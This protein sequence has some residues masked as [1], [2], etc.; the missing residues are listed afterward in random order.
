MRHIDRS[1]RDLHA[2]VGFQGI[3]GAGDIPDAAG[4]LQVVLGYGPVVGGRDIQN[5]QTVQDQVLF[6]EDDPVRL[7]GAVLRKGP[8]HA[9]GVFAPFGCGDE[10]LIAGFHI[11]NGR[12]GIGHIH[13]VQ[14]DLHL[15][16]FPRFDEDC[17]FLRAAGENIHALR[18]DGHA[19]AVTHG[20]K[21]RFGSVGLLP[22]IPVGEKIV[23]PEGPD[24][25][26]LVGRHRE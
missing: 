17:V 22:Q 3:A 9:Q 8:C 15:I 18:V 21:D 5:A 26:I 13:A 24:Q 12:R 19:A 7:V 16:L 20:I 25:L 6:G 4:H 1:V 14:D 11:D 23:R 2:V 10:G